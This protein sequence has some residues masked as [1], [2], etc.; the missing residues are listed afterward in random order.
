MYSK[1]EKMYYIIRENGTS[2][3]ELPYREEFIFHC[4][5]HLL[6]VSNEKYR[7]LEFMENSIILNIIPIST[8]ADVLSYKSR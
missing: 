6:D 5:I 7:L 3:F 8:L 4:L 2:I 1:T